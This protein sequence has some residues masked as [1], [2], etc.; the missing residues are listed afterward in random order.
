MPALA[1]T[2]IAAPFPFA[3]VNRLRDWYL[4]G[5]PRAVVPL[6]DDRPDLGQAP[7]RL[8]QQGRDARRVLDIEAV[9]EI[10][11]AAHVGVRCDL[12]ARVALRG[13]M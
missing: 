13:A 10:V 4:D 5:R 1:D 2:R 11:E 12:E 6:L 8:E 9:P 7:S 3:T